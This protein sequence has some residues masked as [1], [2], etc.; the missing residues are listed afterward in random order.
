MKT[1]RQ[2]AGINESPYPFHYI[3][4]SYK[5]MIDISGDICRDQSVDG[6]VLNFYTA[7]KT[8]K[9]IY[10]SNVG[11]AGAERD[12]SKIEVR[13]NDYSY[14]LRAGNKCIHILVIDWNSLTLPT[15]EKN[16]KRFR[17]HDLFLRSASCKDRPS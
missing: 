2:F 5:K 12:P 4:I 7:V 15:K 3:N 8:W 13:L 1:G 6:C 9:L 10:R 16:R 14:C 17:K 11:A